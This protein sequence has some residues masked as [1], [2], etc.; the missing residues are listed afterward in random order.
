MSAQLGAVSTM[1]VKIEGDFNPNAAMPALAASSYIGQKEKTIAMTVTNHG[2]VAINNIGYTC[3]IG[4]ASYE[5]QY[6]F[7]TPIG[8]NFNM[9]GTAD[10]P[11]AV[12][13][14][15]GTYPME[16]TITKVNGVEN[17]DKL[18]TLKT[19]VSI[20]P[21]CPV[22]RPLVEEYTGLWCGWCP[23]GY[24]ALETMNE[25]YGDDFVALAWHN[26]DDMAITSRYPNQVGGFPYAYINRKNGL[27]PGNIEDEW[28]GYRLDVPIA[29]I[30]VDLVWT[31]AEKTVLKATA[32]T[33]FISE[34]SDSYRLAF[35]VVMDGMQNGSWSQ[36]NYYAGNAAPLEG[37]YAELFTGGKSKVK[38]L[39]FND[40]VAYFPSSEYFGIDGTL[41]ATLEAGK[42]YDSEY[43]IELANVINSSKKQMSQWLQNP[44]HIRVVAMLF[45]TRK[46]FI[47]CNTSGY[48][49]PS[50]VET[51]TGTSAQVVETIYYD[52]NGRRVANPENG[53]FVKID[54]LDN[55]TRRTSKVIR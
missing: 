24:V 7:T 36:S 30:D 20:I 46:N 19:D 5:G 15:L 48:A 54:V 52:L 13:E 18:A 11:V 42:V 33:T 28:P 1:V 55:G 10:L 39:E 3:K 51:L 25:K 29:D 49:V 47:N 4:D 31:N 41:P 8:K 44:D 53:I 35:A 32:H 26:G 45:D 6:T 12:P 43:E 22:N 17:K 38:G 37:K 14:T 2:S 27:D 34:P 40:V 9:S 50:G 23:R 16:F 21:F